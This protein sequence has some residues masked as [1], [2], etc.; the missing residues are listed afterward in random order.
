MLGVDRKEAQM[1]LTRKDLAG[2]IVAALAVLVYAANVQDWWYL[3]SN[4]A[5]AVTMLVVGVIGC[6]VGAR[7][8]GEKLTSP[9]IIGLGL[10]GLVALVVAILA[11]VTAEQS[12]LLA[13]A[14]LVVVLW[15]GATLRHAVTPPPQLT[16]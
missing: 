13:L 6:P 12:A 4:R 3:G 14:V 5:A 11:I 10:L 7:I 15:A 9:A 8:V 16:A 2:A 1:F